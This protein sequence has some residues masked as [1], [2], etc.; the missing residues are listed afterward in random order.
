MRLKNVPGAREVIADSEFV[1]LYPEQQKGNWAA[2]FGN[3][4]PVHIEIGMGKGKFLTGMAMAHPDVN[5]IGIEK[6]SSVLLRAVQKQEELR[7]P[8]LRLIRMDAEDITEVF[9]PGE[10]D[11]IYLNF[12]D[13]WPKDRHAKR[14]LTS[15]TFLARYQKIL[16][17]TGRLEF[18]TDN[19][20]LF[21]FSL[22]SVAESGWRLIA[23]TNDL[24][25]SELKEGNIMTEYEER[26]SAMGN[27]I[28]KLIADQGTE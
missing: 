6:Y 4:D 12:S 23:S 3:D 24:H 22:E 5:Y 10:V 20:S 1:V 19:R 21:E 26:F 2:L 16:T 14:R 25:H 9:A 11:R 13:P 7:L 18:K 17:R 28:Y 15:G 8:N 27:P